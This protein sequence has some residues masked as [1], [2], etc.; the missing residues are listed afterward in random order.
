M[1]DIALQTLL[2][3]LAIV[4]IIAAI[5]VLLAVIF[6][7]L[8]GMRQVREEDKLRKLIKDEKLRAAKEDF[9]KMLEDLKNQTPTKML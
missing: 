5:V 6:S 4:G 8:S 9:D 1:L 3:I 2:K 7:V